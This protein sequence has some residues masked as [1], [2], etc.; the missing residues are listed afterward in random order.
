MNVPIL[1]SS[2]LSRAYRRGLLGW[3]AV[4][5]V[6][7]LLPIIATTLIPGFYVRFPLPITYAVLIGA[8]VC[9][10]RCLEEGVRVR[11]KPG[12]VLNSI[13]LVGVATA[14]YGTLTYCPQ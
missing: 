3:I 7:F 10:A 9:A 2:S 4:A 8:V 13:L 14:L 5:A 11:S 1:G 12:I 6:Y